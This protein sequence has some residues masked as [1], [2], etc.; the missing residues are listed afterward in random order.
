MSY[1]RTSRAGP[2]AELGW[3]QWTFS[4]TGHPAAKIE[5]DPHS[6]TLTPQETSDT[7]QVVLRR[8]YYFEGRVC[9]T[10]T[11]KSGTA[12]A[13]KDF[14]PKPVTACWD[15]QYEDWQLPNLQLF[16]DDRKEGPETFTIELSNPTGGA[17]IG[18]IGS[19]TITLNDDD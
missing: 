9:V 6:M 17:I 5:I 15:D 1:S 3:R 18:P 7:F 8:S 10:L 11:A 4:P 12:T 13:G 19:L 16:N 14:G 2:A